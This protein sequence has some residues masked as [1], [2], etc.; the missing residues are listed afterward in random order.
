VVR[1]PLTKT[2]QIRMAGNSVCPPMACAIVAANLG[3]A[4][5]MEQ[6]VAA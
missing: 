6:P 4:V 2:A 5:P 3:G 1:K